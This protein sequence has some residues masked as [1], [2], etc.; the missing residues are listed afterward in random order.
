MGTWVVTLPVAPPCRCENVCFS[1]MKDGVC[2][3]HRLHSA[4]LQCEIHFTLLRLYIERS[5]LCSPPP[6]SPP[7]LLPRRWSVP[8]LHCQLTQP[9]EWKMKAL[10]VGVASGFPF[11]GR[12]MKYVSELLAFLTDSG[13]QPC[14]RLR[15]RQEEPP[16]PPST[17]NILRYRAAAPANLTPGK[18]QDIC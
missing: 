6:P 4:L 16:R 13:N 1:A 17:G 7:H 11:D 18:V 10:S 5:Y 3:P 14:E 8:I 15:A 12:T 2:H 9:A